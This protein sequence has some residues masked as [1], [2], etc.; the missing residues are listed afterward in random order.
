MFKVAVIEDDIPTSQQLTAWIQ[1]ARTGIQVDNWR[2][3]TSAKSAISA[4]QA[5]QSSMP[6]TRVV[7]VHRCWSC[8]RCPPPF[9]AAS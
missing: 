9:T 2:I 7:T 3:F 4:M 5:L 6:S 8:Q 1:G